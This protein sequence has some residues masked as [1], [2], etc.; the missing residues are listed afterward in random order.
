MQESKGGGEG[1]NPYVGKEIDVLGKH[2]WQI[3]EDAR[4]KEQM[5]KD[6]LCKEQMS[7]DALCKW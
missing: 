7:E 3:S 2:Q 6:A 5:S 4:C 1:R